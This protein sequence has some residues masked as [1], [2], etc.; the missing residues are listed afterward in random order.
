M[1]FL[2]WRQLRRSGRTNILMALLI[3]TFVFLVAGATLAT[4]LITDTLLR[5]VSSNL[6]GDVGV[7]RSRVA[8]RIV[9]MGLGVAA[10]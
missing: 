8:P 9:P 5:P 1:R 10:I 6:G 7:I 2:I 4:T 3:A